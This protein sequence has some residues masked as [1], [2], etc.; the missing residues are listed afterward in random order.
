MAQADGY[1]IIDTEIKA[2]GMKA[3]SKEVEAAVRRMASTVDGLGNKAKIALNKQVNAFSKLNQEYAAQERKVEELK[4]KVS[5]YA[6]QKI[7]TEE[8]K[9]IQDQIDKAIKKLNALQQAQDR[10]EVTGGRRNTTSLKKM[11]YDIEELTNEIKYAEAEL[12]DLE[13]TGKAFT[14]GTD[15]KEAT[16]DME[17]L[18]EAEQ[19]LLNMNNRLGSSYA[20]IKNNV[21]EYGK[22]LLGIDSAHKKAGDS[23]RK[24]SDSVRS[25]GNSAKSANFGL[26]RMLGTS[27][28]FSFVFFL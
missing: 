26:K 12:K 1:I 5:E 10:F 6:N 18:A 24:F 20:S 15:T 14:L 17:R 7:P 4:R 28:L 19:K 2:D 16:A 23:S 8:Y 27:L 25:T 3:G 11:E 22:K 9:A 21:D 13:E